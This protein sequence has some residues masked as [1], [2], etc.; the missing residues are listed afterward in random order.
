[1]YE[2]TS[3]SARE[4]VRR[5]LLR[6]QHM[7]EIQF[8]LN[9][10]L[11][12][13]LRSCPGVDN[14]VDWDR[15]R[16]REDGILG[17]IL[18]MEGDD[19]MLQRLQRNL[20][21]VSGLDSHPYSRTMGRFPSVNTREMM[22]DGGDPTAT[23]SSDPVACP[24]PSRAPHLT[25]RATPD[26]PPVGPADPRHHGAVAPAVP[27]LLPPRDDLALPGTVDVTVDGDDSE[28]ANDDAALSSG[29]GEGEDGDN[30][31]GDDGGCMDE[32]NGET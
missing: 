4:V 27:P 29:D 28:T 15:A 16:H 6:Q 26:R 24:R 9:R 21:R 2:L 32:E 18:G 22:G 14:G 3:G 19:P 5:L 10:A 7:A 11:Q 13:A 8:W 23:S 31:G 25:P 30:E 20:G 12:K 1:M 17:R